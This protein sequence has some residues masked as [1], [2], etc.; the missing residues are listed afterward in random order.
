RVR[1]TAL[2]AYA[3][4]DVPF[5]KLI[6]TLKPA[7]DMSRSSIF[8]V[9][10]NL[11]SF[12]DQIELPGGEAISFVDAWLQS[13]ENLSKFD[14]TLYAGVADKEIKL[15]LVYN[16]ELFTRERIAEMLEQLKHLLSQIV[17]QPNADIEH[18]SLV[19]PRAKT[20]LPNPTERF[21]ASPGETIQK[22]FS[23]Q[24]R[25]PPHQPAVIDAHESWTYRLLDERSNQLANFLRANGVEAE[26]TVAI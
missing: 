13:E 1:K 9:Y 21:D 24:A 20:F 17:E 23:E 14:L 26:N 22:L 15:A 12:S 19:T 10:F 18:F 3:N 4:Q 16:T 25:R 7:R 8:Q 5:E 6:E 11:F 2:D